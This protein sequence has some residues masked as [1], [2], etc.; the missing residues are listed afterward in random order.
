[1]VT[2][3]PSAYCVSFSRWCDHLQPEG[4][5]IFPANVVNNYLLQQK[6]KSLKEVRDCKAQDTSCCG[7]RIER[8]SLVSSSSEGNVMCFICRIFS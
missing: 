2:F 3:P 1:M 4:S 6:E 7:S 5:Q 8:G